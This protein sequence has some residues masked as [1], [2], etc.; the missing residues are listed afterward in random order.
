M[1]IDQSFNQLDITVASRPE[2]VLNAE[3]KSQSVISVSEKWGME[4]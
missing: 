2:F 4:Q 1:M 3:K